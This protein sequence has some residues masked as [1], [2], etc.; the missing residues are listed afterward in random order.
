[1]TDTPPVSPTGKSF[2][3]EIRTLLPSKNAVPRSH[4]AAESAARND[5]SGHRNRTNTRI[6]GNGAFGEIFAAWMNAGRPRFDGAIK[7]HILIFKQNAAQCDPD[8]PMVKWLIDMMRD[9]RGREKTS[10]YPHI[11]IFTKDDSEHCRLMPVEFQPCVKGEER[12]IVRI[13][14]WVK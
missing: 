13:E 7:I 1:M 9:A 3:C 8:N 14:E 4:W 10:D 11:G 5:W 2:V 12:M 6:F